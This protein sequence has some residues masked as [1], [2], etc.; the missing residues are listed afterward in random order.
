MPNLE[1]VLAQLEYTIHNENGF[2]VNTYTCIDK[3]NSHYKLNFKGKGRELNTL[4]GITL[5]LKGS[6]VQYRGE[7]QFS[8]KEEELY[9]VKTEKS[10]MAYIITKYNGIGQK[11]V[12][13]I[14]R[15]YGP[16]YSVLSDYDRLIKAI[17]KKYALRIIEQSKQ[18]SKVQEVY[19]LFTSADLLTNKK[20]IAI[21]E[22]VSLSEIY[23]NPFILMKSEYG[24]LSFLKV[25]KLCVYLQNVPELTKIFCSLERIKE[26]VL[27]NLTDILFQKGHTWI[28]AT[29]LIKE[30]E[31]FLNSGLNNN[32][33]KVNESDIK[34]ALN[35]LNK[36]HKIKCEKK[37]NILR[38]YNAFFY[39][40]ENFIAQECISR[41]N[42]KGKQFSNNKIDNLI[43]DFEKLNKITLAD[44]QKLAIRSVV[45]NRICVITGS[46]GTGKTTVLNAAI[47]VLS[48]LRKSEICLLAPTGRAARRMSFSTN[49]PAYTLHHAL[50]ISTESDS[51]IPVATKKIEADYVFVDESSMC[52][53]AI[54]YRL[55]QQCDKKC[56]F[57]FIGDPNQLPSV[58]AGN[59]L[60]DLITSESVPVVK[61]K[62]IYRQAKDSNIIINANRILNNSSAMLQGEDFI[63]Y[64]MYSAAEIQEKVVSSFLEELSRTGDIFETQIIT[65][66]RRDGYLSAYQINKKIQSII[67]P[68]VKGRYDLPANGYNFR[69]GDKIICSKNTKTIKNGDMGLVERVYKNGENYVMTAKFDDYVEE[70]DVDRAKEL[71]IALAFAITVH[72]SQGS[73][74]KSVL[75][76]IAAENRVMLKRN[77]FYT[78]I[79]RAKE[80]IIIVGPKSEI[81][82]AVLNNTK[83]E[84]N[85]LL[86]QR[87]QKCSKE[88][89]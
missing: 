31:K 80:K 68:Y 9:P 5:K 20:R 74:F 38:I 41:V 66:K 86:C 57:V 65:P 83:Y 79:T 36:E 29:V 54:I 32:E 72:K 8:V 45:N 35:S 78:A 12:E 13:K 59:V 15:K 39:D 19:D 50:G 69:V 14:L 62:Y 73:E 44:N 46:A 81:K 25:N 40:S 26:G 21:A 56:N 85:T 89:A 7:E 77:L 84:R 22:K 51:I 23:S 18:F 37:A 27:Y 64:D 82:R 30:T 75:L 17:N 60:D 63:I 10:F 11:T 58:G 49:M 33:L 47:Y 53:I 43:K 24:G 48:Q 70:F 67:N 52:D 2:V 42:S 34:K 71:G 87:I 28:D 76:P 3:N 6:W 16:D 1:T 4:K 55:F 61:L 88:A